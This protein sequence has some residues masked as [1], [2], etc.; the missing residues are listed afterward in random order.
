MPWQSM[1]YTT[2][3][4]AV[5]AGV[6]MDG[7]VMARGESQLSATM[8]AIIAEQGDV[9][10][11][12]RTLP[13]VV[14]AV[15]LISSTM[16]QI[17][18][19]MEPEGTPVP[20]WLRRPRKYG[21]QLDPAD[22]MGYIIDSQ[23]LYGRAYLQATCIAEGDAPSWRLDALSP[24]YVQVRESTGAVVGR[25]F[26]VEG[27]PMPEV[28]ASLA[29]AVRGRAYLLHIP[30]RV[31]VANPAG[32]TPL[33]EAARILRGQVTVEKYVSELFDNGTFVGGVL[34][35]D[36]DIT[37][38]QAKTAQTDFMAARAARKLAVMGSGLSYRNELANSEELQ[39]IEARGFNQ[40]VIWALFGIPQ[41]M[42][43]S[44]MMSGGSSLSYANAQDNYRLFVSACL[45]GFADQIVGS[46]SRLF[47]PGRNADEETRIT[48]D[49]D[50]YQGEATYGV[51][52]ADESGTD[53]ADPPGE[54]P[55]AGG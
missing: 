4:D 34:T 20:E 39:L 19:K 10:A 33:T 11:D 28:P 55:P 26:V 24:Q 40:S 49:W 36:Q 47:P 8:D 2:T 14:A 9:P 6:G 22:L 5:R 17:P 53:A 1:D 43:G 32:T 46:L 54:E 3:T 52:V 21:A 15:R 30:Y 7:P 13:A 41:A 37:P 44:N 23:A 31:S 29:T 35:T 42:M 12:I 48:F 38:A 18:W 45:R 25:T 50:A 16:A 51:N 27:V